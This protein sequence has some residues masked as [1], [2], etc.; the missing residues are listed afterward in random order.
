MPPRKRY[1]SGDWTNVMANDA[2]ETFPVMGP[3]LPPRQNSESD[4]KLNKEVQVPNHKDSDSTLD[5]QTPDT[6]PKPNGHSKTP[7]DQLNGTGEE[8]AVAGAQPNETTE[9]PDTGYFQASHAPNQDHSRGFQGQTINTSQF[10]PPPIRVENAEPLETVQ[11]DVI[12]PIPYERDPKKLIGYLIPCP[13]PSLPEGVPEPPQRFIIYTPPHPPFLNKPH[14]ESKTES[15]RKEGIPHF[16]RRKWTEELREAKMRTPKNGKTTKWKRL[17][18]RA[19]KATDWGIDKTKSSNLE[20]LNRVARMQDLSDEKADD[21]YH[22]S[23]SPEEM[24]LLYPP[25]LLPN[26]DQGGSG[27]EAL[28]EEFVGSLNRTK[29]TATRNSIIAALLFPPAIVVDT[30]AVP[31]WPFGVSQKESF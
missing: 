18:W 4:A 14:A 24:L 27:G 8:Q 12:S 6:A 7:P 31:V 5:A 16:C 19:T 26:G 25:N 30:F 20:F 23:V 11:E 10:A 21:V 15:W 1:Y 17:K 3:E 9:Q 29:K 28:K 2:V 22:K 13:K